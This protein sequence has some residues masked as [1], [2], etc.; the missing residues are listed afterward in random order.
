MNICL[1]T[2]SLFKLSTSILILTFIAGCGFH[3]RGAVSF[4]TWLKTVYI[5]PDDPYEPLQKTVRRTLERNKITL[6]T[7]I[8]KETAVLELTTPDFTESILALNAMGQSQRFKLTIS[9]QY[10][11]SYAGNLLR[12]LTTIQSSRDFTLAP[13]QILSGDNE[14][15][16]IKDELLQEA[17]SQLFRQLYTV[18]LPD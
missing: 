8:N 1:Q 15:R 10:K 6:V 11:L 16:L 4:P 18:K 12:P 17:T 5:T 14:R 9:F 3:L 2:N 7:E 13:G